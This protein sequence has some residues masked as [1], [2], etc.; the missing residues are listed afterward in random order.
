MK[1]RELVGSG[2]K[3]GLVMLPIVVVGVALNLAFPATF[4]VG[5]PVDPFRTISIVVLVVGVAIWLW[6]VVLILA[7][8]PRGELITGGPFALVK[9]PLYTAVALLVLPWA[10]FLL[11][12]WLGVVLGAALYVASRLFAPDE[13]RTL[14]AKFGPSWRRYSDAVLLPWV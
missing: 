8:V 13:E 12:T 10:G 4:S 5:G 3:I 9:H 11:N 7:K 2:D 1:I 6:T 14:A